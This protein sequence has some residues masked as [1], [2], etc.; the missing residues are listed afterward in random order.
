MQTEGKL[1]PGCVRATRAQRCGLH[2]R[3]PLTTAPPRSA[4]R[5]YPSA[6]AAYGII[7]RADGVKGLW[8]G[9]GPN[10]GRNAIINAAE[11]ASYDQVRSWPL[12]QRRCHV[13]LTWQAV[14]VAGEAVADGHGSLPRQ[15]AHAPALG[16]LSCFVFLH[17]PCRT[18]A[19]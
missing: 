15:H 18:R 17:P 3:A 8:T 12:T 16:A 19:C 9:V 10:I 14:I 5:K 1:A 2:S 13:A 7:A 11:L 4:V 6:F